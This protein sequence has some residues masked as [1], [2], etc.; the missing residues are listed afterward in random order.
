MIIT[1]LEKVSKGRIKIYLNDEP[2]FMLYRG[3][4]KTL[5]VSVSDR[6]KAA[7]IN[8][9]DR[10]LSEEERVLPFY[11]CLLYPGMDIE[12]E[13]LEYIYSQVLNKRAKLRALNILTKQDK[14]EKELRDKLREGLYP[15]VVID[16][17]LE[18]VK[19]Y[20]YIDD[21]RYARNY[22]SYRINTKSVRMLEMELRQRGI[23]QDTIERVLD[24]IISEEK[25][26]EKALIIKLAEKKCG[27]PLEEKLPDKEDR[28][29]WA[30]LYR[31]LMGK[32]FSYEKIKGALSCD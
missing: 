27:R 18:Y 13:L 32:G 25:F 14:T 16:M 1:K 24:D 17:A 2:A 29:N 5:P 4:I 3:E 9:L 26:D 28:K 12:G 8:E 19:G 31:Y 7:Y 23:A 22:A 21:E 11:G 15:A 20:S 30:K 6:E 10:D